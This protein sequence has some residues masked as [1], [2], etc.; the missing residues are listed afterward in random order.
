MDPNLKIT[1]TPARRAFT[2]HDRIWRQN[3]FV[4]PVVSRRSKGIS[5]GVNLNPDKV[6]NFDCIYCS[7]DR[8]IPPV[9]RE[10]DLVELRR[11][12]AAM[13]EICRTGEIYKHDPFNSIPDSLRRIND[14]AFSGDGEPTTFAEFGEACRIAAELK[15]AAGLAGVKIVVIT[16]A[17]MFHRPAVREALRFLDANNGEIWAKLDAGTQAYYQLVDRTSIPF[18]RVLENILQCAKDR[19]T[20]I[21]SLLMKVHGEG[22]SAAE[23]A[24]IGD[25][26]SEIAAAGGKLKLIQL[27]TVARATTE[28]Y[29][30]ALSEAELE[31]I[32]AK[33]R[34]R[35]PGVPV[36][37]YP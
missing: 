3:R 20:V 6:C 19:P 16:N 28:A 8:K 25:R 23:V 13:I 35:L 17:T 15:N 10:V 33:I 1:Q 34:A 7:V 36:E 11:E 14:I 18:R 27:Y 21:Q 4:Y 22:P 5:I 29:A 12:L 32:A 30:T 26:L 9:V 37:V 2:L 24:A 31:E